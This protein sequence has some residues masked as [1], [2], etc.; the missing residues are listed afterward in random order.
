MKIG[1]PNN[2]L[3]IELQFRDLNIKTSTF[4]K[5]LANKT[6]IMNQGD[7]MYFMNRSR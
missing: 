6:I 7:I 1:L 2:E 4:V 5:R 3:N